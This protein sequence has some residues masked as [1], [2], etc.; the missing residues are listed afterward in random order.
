MLTMS[1]FGIFILFFLVRQVVTQEEE[2]CSL[3]MS[4]AIS[5]NPE[6]FAMP[7]HLSTF[8]HITGLTEVASSGGSY[9]VDAKYAHLVS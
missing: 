8:I 1:L 6:P 4:P 7:L 2:D 5:K 3:E 9:G